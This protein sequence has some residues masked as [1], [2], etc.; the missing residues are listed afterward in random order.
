MGIFFSEFIFQIKRCAL[1][2]QFSFSQSY[3]SHCCND[4]C[5][6]FPVVRKSDRITLQLS[7]SQILL[8]LKNQIDNDRRE[9]YFTVQQSGREASFNRQELMVALQ[10]FVVGAE[11]LFMWS[12][13]KKQRRSSLVETA[14]KAP[15]IYML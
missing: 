1:P 4:V 11:N 12:S 13:V 14:G 8:L 6:L 7:E 10:H 5:S 9:R 15:K 3:N 2:L